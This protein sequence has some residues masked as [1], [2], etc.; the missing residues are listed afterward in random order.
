MT[1]Q[2]SHHLPSHE[3]AIWIWD[4]KKTSPD[5]A[6]IMIVGSQLQAV[7]INFS[8]LEVTQFVV[9]C[10]SNPKGIE[11]TLIT[12][13]QY[14]KTLQWLPLSWNTVYNPCPLSRKHCLIYILSLPPIHL[15]LF[16]S[17]DAFRVSGLPSVT[18]PEL[19]SMTDL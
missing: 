4:Q 8:C 16:F 19:P 10:Y 18:R 14:T 3:D 15:D 17:S 12:S 5:H 1:P 11:Q 13:S 7:R 2:S 9:F 6:V